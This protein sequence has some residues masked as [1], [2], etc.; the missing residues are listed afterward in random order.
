MN[1]PI[2]TLIATAL[3][4]FG[5]Q[6]AM[7]ANP[8]EFDVPDLGVSTRTRA[9]VRAEAVQ[10]TAERLHAAPKTEFWVPDVTAEP[11]AW[12]TAARRAEARKAQAE[13]FHT[14]AIDL[15]I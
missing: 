7:A 5:S 10:A 1:T 8:S 13:R 6:A 2:R 12:T 15:T 4:A 3:I 14:Q 9:E 11:S